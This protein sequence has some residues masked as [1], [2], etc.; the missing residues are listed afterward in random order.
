MR[1]THFYTYTLTLN[2]IDSLLVKKDDEISFLSILPISLSST[3]RIIL[4]WSVYKFIYLVCS[5]HPFGCLNVI[6]HLNGC[7]DHRCSFYCGSFILAGCWIVWDLPWGLS[8][9]GM[10]VTCLYL[11][12]IIWVG[13]TFLLSL[14]T[15]E[16]L[17]CCV[18]AF[19]IFNNEWRW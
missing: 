19:S 2:K 13:V 9:S 6:L 1:I 16:T 15:L 12:I 4:I 14:R 11:W 17:F 3:Y 10:S 18:L 8:C 7:S 5:H